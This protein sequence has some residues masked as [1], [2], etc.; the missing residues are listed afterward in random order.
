MLFGLA[1]ALQ[2][3]GKSVQHKLQENGRSST[4]SRRHNWIRDA[5]VVTEI[6]FACVLV[7]GAGLVTRSFIKVMDVDLGFVPERVAAMR[8]DLGAD[9]GPQEKINAFFAELKS[10]AGGL[11][12]VQ[13]VA[14][15]D[16]V[17]LGGT[18][19]YAVAGVGQTYLRGEYPE[20]YIHVIG[21]GYLQTMG[22]AL[23][24]GREFTERDMAGSEPVALINES[25]AKTLWPGARGGGTVG[26]GRW[27][28]ERESAAPGCRL[29]AGRTSSRPGTERRRRAVSAD[30]PDER[31]GS[32]YLVIRTAVAPGPLAAGVR[33]V[34]KRISPAASIGEVRPV[35]DWVDKAVAPRRFLVG[36]LAAFSTF[37]VVLAALGDLCGDCLWGQ[38]AQGGDGD[39]HG[40]R[41]VG[42]EIAGSHGCRDVDAGGSGDGDWK[43]G[44]V[45]FGRALG[46]LLFEVKFT[47]PATYVGM[48]V[49][50]AGVAALA[51]YL[52]AKGIA[53]ID[54][55]GV[56]RGE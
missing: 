2:L 32:I 48:L 39:T 1:P 49:I 5:L 33:E 35:Q 42:R 4:G 41:G 46:A 15:T 27:H 25:L 54:P 52:P 26:V 24:A 38:P 13:G 21:D 8:L 12:G 22:I 28:K 47:D 37:A 29:G 53:K 11:P 56:L 6:V 36:V 9:P 51:G 18:R 31:F 19:S 14:L 10:E 3:S 7:V 43:C 50:I 17:P 34:L 55:M 45:V 30:A 40:A 23:R 44:S 20:G 16:F